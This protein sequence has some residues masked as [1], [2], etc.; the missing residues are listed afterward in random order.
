LQTIFPVNRLG[1]L[2]DSPKVYC[3]TCHNGV[4]KPLF[5]VSMVKEFPDLI[6]ASAAPEN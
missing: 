3:A 2:G 5:G 4:Y 6:G 1:V